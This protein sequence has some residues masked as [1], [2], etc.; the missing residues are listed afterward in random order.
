MYNSIA[1]VLTALTPPR[2]AAAE[3]RAYAYVE[4]NSV[5]R[6]RLVDLLRL[7]NNMCVETAALKTAQ[8]AV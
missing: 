1:A 5:T 6:S 3:Q 8:A 4:C 2:N 7:L